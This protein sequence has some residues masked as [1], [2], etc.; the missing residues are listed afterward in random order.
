MNL[1]ET[2]VNKFPAGLSFNIDP[3]RHNLW[4]AL[5]PLDGC[6]S[7]DEASIL[8]RFND[9][10]NLFAGVSEKKSIV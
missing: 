10:L 9:V 2:R 4:G 5:L 6:R 7:R 1:S 8:I 3:W